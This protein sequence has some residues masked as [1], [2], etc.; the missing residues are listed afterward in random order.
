[1]GAA[2]CTDGWSAE[3][4]RCDRLLDAVSFECIVSGILQSTAQEASFAAIESCLR[5]TLLGRQLG[6]LE[7]AP[8]RRS[9]NQPNPQPEFGVHAARS[10]RAIDPPVCHSATGSEACSD[11]R[12]TASQHNVVRALRYLANAHRRAART[13]ERAA[14][15]GLGDVKAHG[16]AADV[17]RAAQ[18][19]AIRRRLAYL[20]VAT[21][22]SHGDNPAAISDEAA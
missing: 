19:E 15:R 4:S 12:L 3:I 7:K 22:K 11:E 1:M 20:M 17:H 8:A 18:V 21:R 2:S 14:S 13:H 16:R 6:F 5:A 10:A 9:D